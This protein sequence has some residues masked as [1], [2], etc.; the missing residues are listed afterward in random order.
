MVWLIGNKGMLG[1]EVALE[2]ARRGVKFVGTDR[3]VDITDAA[4][5]TE[6]VRAQTEPVRFIVNCSAYTAV[7][8]AEDEPERARALNED[9]IR[10]IARTAKAVGAKTIHISTDYVFDGTASAPYAED[11]PV[12]PVGVYGKTKATGEK[13]LAA[14]TEAFYIL[15]TAWLYGKYGKNFVRTIIDA[16][17]A[18][19]EI[20]VVSDQF[21]TPTYAKDLAS[22]IVKIIL[23]DAEGKA[24]PFGIY[25]YAGLGQTSWYEFTREIQTQ[26]TKRGLLTRGCAV[27][28]CTTADYPTKARRPA[29]SVLS[30]DKIQRALGIRIPAWEESLAAFLD[31]IAQ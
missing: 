25:H 4:A 18:R 27:R 3:N 26:A 10:N 29:Y 21:G 15:R 7:D 9:G 17:N 31:D 30:K 12:N 8:T 19:A 23:L 6:F 16:M 13:A 14:E 20:K 2:L 22:V 1:S 28:P 5:L 11:T 24:A